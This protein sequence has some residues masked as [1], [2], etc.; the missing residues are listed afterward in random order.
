MTEQL[1]PVGNAM[2]ADI[3]AHK[4]LAGK[5]VNHSEGPDLANLGKLGSFLS[6]NEVDEM[7][8]LELQSRFSLP[9]RASSTLHWVPSPIQSCRL[10]GDGRIQWLIHLN[11]HIVKRVFACIAL[12]AMYF[13]IVE[14]VMD[15]SRGP[16]ERSRAKEEYGRQKAAQT[17]TW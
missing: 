9:E 4:T 7:Y 12:V 3:T 1:Q 5:M 8:S 14:Y 17:Y 6:G 15:L 16:R 10:R 13:S 2:G 11:E